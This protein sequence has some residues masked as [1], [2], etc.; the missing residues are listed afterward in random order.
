MNY[1][2]ILGVDAGASLQEI[3]KAYKTLALTCHPDKV[4]GKEALFISIQEAYQVLSDE[5]KRDA[6]DLSLEQELSDKSILQFKFYLH[7]EALSLTLYEYVNEALQ[8]EGDEC[9]KP[10]E[11]IP[12]RAHITKKLKHVIN[13]ITP[14]EDY[15]V[16]G[17]T[18]VI[19]TSEQRK[20]KNLLTSNLK[21][22]VSSYR[23]LCIN[24][25]KKKLYDICLGFEHTQEMSKIATLVG[26]HEQL[27]RHF[28]NDLNLDITNGLLTLYKKDL[29]TTNNF[30][31][32]AKE[33]S[34][35]QSLSDTIE[36]LAEI[37]FL[38][39]RTFNLLIKSIPYDM[40]LWRELSTYQYYDIKMPSYVEALLHARKNVGSVGE[41]YCQLHLLNLLNNEHIDIIFKLRKVKVWPFLLNINIEKQINPGHAEAL[42]WSGPESIKKLTDELNKL[43][44]HGL[45][46]LPF[47]SA[48]GLRAMQLGLNLKAQLKS[49]IELDANHQ[50]ATKEEFIRSFTKKLHSEDQ[51]MTMHRSYWKII[52]ANILIAAT[53]IGLLALGVNIAVNKRPFFSQTKREKLI[54][55]IDHHSSLSTL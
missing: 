15:W 50:K 41:A 36:V 28:K 29:L 19:L 12:N 31:E 37:G 16:R 39:Q 40:T 43:V 33:S 52:L 18:L 10:G 46:I 27:H 7:P 53:G 55:S 45:S 38:S 21:M 25:Q 48:Q 34:R 26:G 35:A 20:R 42:H 6:Y 11:K 54:E 24:N 4:E 32:L 23:V 30:I 51:F 22:A 44:A 17:D 1:Y 9:L 2:S 14:E 5:R 8:L 3:K 47:D 13:T 49:Y